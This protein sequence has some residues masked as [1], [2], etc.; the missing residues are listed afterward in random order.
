MIKILN[1]FSE[2]S[3][4]LA[5]SKSLASLDQTSLQLK[6]NIKYFFRDYFLKKF[7]SSQKRSKIFNDKINNNK[8]E[9]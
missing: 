3:L 8:I 4:G 7:C 2:N 5:P 6:I 1:I 9:N